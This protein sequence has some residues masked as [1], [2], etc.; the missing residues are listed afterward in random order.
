MYSLEEITK[1]AVAPE[2]KRCGGARAA[3]NVYVA[4]DVGPTGKLLK[5]M[6][7][8]LR[9]RRYEAFRGVMQYGEEAGADL[10]H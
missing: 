4:L 8:P 7:D 5:P 2:K 6:G 10:I 1:T 9:L 3:R